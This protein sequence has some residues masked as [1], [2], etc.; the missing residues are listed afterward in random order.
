MLELKAPTQHNPPNMGRPSAGQNDA[1]FDATEHC[2]RELPHQHGKARET[3]L[4]IYICSTYVCIYIYIYIHIYEHT[5]IY[6]YI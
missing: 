1:A 3:N 5:H 4:Y 6:I 2:S